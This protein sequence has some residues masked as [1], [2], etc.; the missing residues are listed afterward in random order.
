MTTITITMGTA[1]RTFTVEDPQ[2]VYSIVG[3]LTLSGNVVTGKSPEKVAEEPKKT[4]PVKSSSTKKTT[5][6]KRPA[7][8]KD[9][10]VVF[11]AETGI[12]KVLDASTKSMPRSKAVRTVANNRLKAVGFQ[13]SKELSG[14][15]IPTKTGKP[16]KKAVEKLPALSTTVTAA[17]IT[18]VYDSWEANKKS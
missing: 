16:S 17:E 8:I 15:I 14:W 5:G 11:E 6:W 9:H 3:M 13:W 7:E 1:V 18:A 2:V 10:E 12:V 4:A